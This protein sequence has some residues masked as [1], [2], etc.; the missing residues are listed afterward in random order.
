M[1]SVATASD[2]YRVLTVIRD[3][4][5]PDGGEIAHRAS[6]S[7]ASVPRI[8][9]RLRELGYVTPHGYRIAQPD[10]LV[11]GVSACVGL[12]YDATGCA[13]SAG[14]R[15]MAWRIV[16]VLSDGPMGRTELA[17][18]LDT[19]TNAGNFVRALQMLE[20]HGTITDA[21]AITPA[22]RAALETE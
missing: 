3:V 21:P 12:L 6:V 2:A 9:G 8:I 10:R 15:D 16:A 18:T 7:S 17:T 13:Y 5:E 20:R 22:G 11:E 19:H 4:Q 14:P 1:R